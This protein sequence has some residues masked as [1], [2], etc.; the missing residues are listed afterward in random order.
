M[1]LG[2]DESIQHAT[3]TGRLLR[4]RRVKHDLG[5]DLMPR[6][7]LVFGQI[8]AACSN[9]A[10]ALRDGKDPSDVRWQSTS[11]STQSLRS[12]PPAWTSTT[13]QLATGSCGFGPGVCADLQYEQVGS[14]CSQV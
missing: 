11:V 9:L 2:F 6:L 4:L 5:F 3:C 12:R 10:I 1:F 14:S 8:A 7:R 13:S